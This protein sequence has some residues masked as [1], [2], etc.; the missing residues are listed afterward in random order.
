MCNNEKEFNCRSYTYLDQT[1]ITHGNL[2]LLSADSRY[3]SLNGS[4]KYRPRALF[5]EKDC[6]DASGRKGK[7]S[8]ISEITGRNS[9]PAIDTP[10]DMQRPVSPKDGFKKPGG[11]G[12][13]HHQFNGSH[14]SFV[15]RIGSKG[16]GGA[17]PVDFSNELAYDE[18][19]VELPNFNNKNRDCIYNEFT[20]EKT[21]GKQIRFSKRERVVAPGNVLNSRGKRYTDLFNAS[22][23]IESLDFGEAIIS[24]VFSPLGAANGKK[25]KAKRDAN[26]Q[27][28]QTNVQNSPPMVSLTADCQDECLRRGMACRS[29]IVEYGPSVGTEQCFILEDAAEE[30]PDV[31]DYSKYGAYFEK[32]CLRGKNVCL[33]F[34]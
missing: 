33:N 15:N 27:I 26:Q 24:N 8:F 28:Q 18:P 31:L 10:L 5:A 30:R 1:I 11:G 12:L 29:F 19:A 20:F 21:Y 9:P 4:M 14:P 6:R 22:S 16:G 25:A 17:P 2:C 34:G 7:K 13:S 3:T 32:I 23:K